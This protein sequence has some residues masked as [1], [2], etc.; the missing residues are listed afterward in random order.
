MDVYFV[1]IYLNN[2]DTNMQL[3]ILSIKLPVILGM[4]AAVKILWPVDNSH[5]K[6][7]SMPPPVSPPYIN[8]DIG[9]PISGATM[10]KIRPVI[11]AAFKS[12]LNL[13]A[14]YPTINPTTIFT[15]ANGISLGL[16]ITPCITLVNPP[17]SAPAKGPNI[18]ATKIVP[19]VSKNNSGIC[20]V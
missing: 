12:N 9:V 15:I 5:A 2:I 1:G 20:K 3:A 8:T 14:V 11:I 19:T 17:V 13:L 6:I 10:D 4:N 16:V 7:R 18:A